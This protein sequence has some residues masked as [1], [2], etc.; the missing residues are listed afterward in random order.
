M[1]YSQT[2]SMLT[3]WKKEEELD[4][5]NDVSSVPLPKSLRHLQTA[6]GNFFAGRTKSP[7]FKKK[8]NGG[9]AEF[10]KAAF[11]FKS[12]LV[13]IAKCKE[14]LAIRW[15]R[16]LP[17][18]TKPSTITIKLDPSGRWF[19]S[20][21]IDDPTNQEFKPTLRL[22]STP[23]GQDRGK[24][25]RASRSGLALSEAMPLRSTQSN[26]WGQGRVEVPTDKKVGIDLVD[27]L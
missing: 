23:F 19:V 12:G 13:Y 3:S 14:P 17:K 5:L 11:K 2:S 21:R 4:F 22:P 1:G 18:D 20:W 25:L 6:F 9:S 16:Q 7:N 15:S 8:R 24:P 10:T 27:N 26:A